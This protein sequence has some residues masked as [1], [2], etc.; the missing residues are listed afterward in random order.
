[1][2]VKNLL[3]KY[4]AKVRLK[5][6]WSERPK[7]NSLD[8]TPTKFFSSAENFG[9]VIYEALSSGLF[10]IL[11]KKLKKKELTENKFAMNINFD[12]K[13]INK[14][15]K[16]ILKNKRYIKSLNYK[17]KCFNFIKT[18]HNWD[19]I[20]KDYIKKYLKVLSKNEIKI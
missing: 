7:F 13:T 18:N 12:L 17:K 2:L 5:K 19:L 15:I 6:S 16:Q 14:S 10:L 4:C 9:L 3:L 8:K 1:M 11:N 20:S